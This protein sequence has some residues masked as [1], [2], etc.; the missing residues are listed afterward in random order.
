MANSFD[1]FKQYC[2]EMERMNAETAHQQHIIEFRA[3]CAKQISDAIPEIVQRAK[4]EALLEV[5][6]EQKEEA[7]VQEREQRLHEPKVDVRVDTE[8]IMD[9]IRKAFKK[10]FH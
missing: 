2:S 9:Q 5:R 6:N 7:K 10:A 3:M 4:E 8:S 1:Y